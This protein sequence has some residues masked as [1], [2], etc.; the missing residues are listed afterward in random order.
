MAFKDSGLE[1]CLWAREK[2]A[3]EWSHS[4]DTLEQCAEFIGKTK[5]N[6]KKVLEGRAKST[7]GWEVKE[8]M[9]KVESQF[10]LKRL[11]APIGTYE[12][13]GA[14]L[15]GGADEDGDMAALK[16]PM[17][18]HPRTGVPITSFKKVR[19]VV[20]ATKLRPA[21]PFALLLTPFSFS[22]QALITS[23]S[24]AG[25]DSHL[26][27]PRRVFPYLLRHS[28]ATLAATSNPPVPVVV[29]QKVMRH[30]SSKMLLDVYAKAGDE[31][32]REGLG[33]FKL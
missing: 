4:F 9:R 30:S 21:T 19:R 14:G 13:A 8:G 20:K 6:I 32:L 31:V 16:G 12:Y 5:A 33:N 3:Q 24:R 28:F 26:G 22:L 25:V 17:F 29:A 1:E 2:G 23:A 27:E 10:K 11:K 18:L 15:T 7:G